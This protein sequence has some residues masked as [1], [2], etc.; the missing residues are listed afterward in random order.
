MEIGVTLNKDI[1][2]EAINGGPMAGSFFHTDA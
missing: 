2:M 1:K